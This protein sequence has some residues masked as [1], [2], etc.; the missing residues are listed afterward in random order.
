MQL[1]VTTSAA[2]PKLRGTLILATE[3][4]GNVG[5]L[6]VDLVL[7]TWRAVHVGWLDEDTL[8]PAVGNAGGPGNLALGLE[9]WQLPNNQAVFLLQQRA[10]AAPG[11]Q[12]T[13]AAHL[14]AWVHS[15]GFEQVPPA[16]S[17]LGCACDWFDADCDPPRV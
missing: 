8:L 16:L 14:A 2:L 7:S 12:H 9:L 5:Q 17:T 3:G 6:A 13:F 10:P 1:H 15:A 4:P 11:A